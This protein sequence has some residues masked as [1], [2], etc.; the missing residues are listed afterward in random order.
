MYGL[1]NSTDRFRPARMALIQYC[2]KCRPVTSAAARDSAHQR[3]LGAVLLRHTSWQES[4]RESIDTSER[5]REA[6]FWFGSA[7]R[8]ILHVGAESTHQSA[9]PLRTSSGERTCLKCS[10]TEARAVALGDRTDQR[11]LIARCAQA[12]GD[13]STRDGTDRIRA[14]RTLV[15]NVPFSRVRPEAG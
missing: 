11:T 12:V 15:L 7:P 1:R 14:W 5:S 10:N 13:T 9:R 2:S 8:A 6:V 3:I 4:S